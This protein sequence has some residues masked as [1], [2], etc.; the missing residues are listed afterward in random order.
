[1]CSLD[2]RRLAVATGHQDRAAAD[3]AEAA[4]ILDTLGLAERADELRREAT[5]VE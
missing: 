4:R 5:A 1:V 2:D 3:F